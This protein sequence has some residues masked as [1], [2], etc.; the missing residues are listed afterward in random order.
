MAIKNLNKRLVETLKIKI[1]GKSTTVRKS[2]KGNDFQAPVKFD[3]FL[4][5]GLD[6]DAKDNFIPDEGIMKTLGEKPKSLPIL[7]LTDDIDKNFQTAYACYQGSKRFCMGDGETAERREGENKYK[8]VKCD[9]ETCDMFLSKACKP[10]GILSCMLPQSEKVGGVA[11]FRTH[12]WNSIINIT[13]SLEAIKLITGGVLFGI[14]L[15]MELIDKQTEE[16]GKVKVVNIVYNGSMQKL[17]IESGR[18]KQ[19]RI[20][21]SVSMTNQNNI[22]DNSG[23]LEDHDNPEDVETEFYNQEVEAEPV[24]AK[25]SSPEKV[26]EKLAEKKEVEKPVEIKKPI[27]KDELF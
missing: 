4:V 12:S 27:S 18:Q 16:H 10:S 8:Q 25:G 19:L 13:S 24:I 11:K 1:G 20:D 6:K 14:P 7:L 5:T 21:G 22:L 26:S 15:T 2:K 23:V 9:P 3:Y 17:Q